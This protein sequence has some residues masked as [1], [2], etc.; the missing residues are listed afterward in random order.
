MKEKEAD[1][2]PALEELTS[3]LECLIVHGLDEGVS[4]MGEPEPEPGL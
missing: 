1:Q 3:T 2:A 4:G